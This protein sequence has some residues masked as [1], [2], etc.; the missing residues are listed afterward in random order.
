MQC[1]WHRGHA[2][3][4]FKRLLPRQQAQALPDLWK[5]RLVRFCS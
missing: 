5:T 1:G 2:D 4:D 3:I